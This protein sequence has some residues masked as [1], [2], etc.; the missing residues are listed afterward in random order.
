MY[1]APQRAGTSEK[2][3]MVRGR[4]EIG[5]RVLCLTDNLCVLPPHKVIGPA[6]IGLSCWKAR[7]ALAHKEPKNL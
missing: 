2:V 1:M 3:M 5:P 4:V 7:S 6:L